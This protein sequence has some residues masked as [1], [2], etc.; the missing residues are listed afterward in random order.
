MRRQIT[1]L[2]TLAICLVASNWVTTGQELKR[3]TNSNQELQGNLGF[4]GLGANCNGVN[5]GS[6]TQ[7][8]ANLFY[9]EPDE[10]DQHLVA[11]W[12]FE[13]GP[14]PLDDSSPS[15]RNNKLDVSGNIRFEDGIAKFPFGENGAGLKTASGPQMLP[16][17]AM[18]L[19]IRFKVN[20]APSDTI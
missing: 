10:P 4:T 5:F 18:T 6:N 14:T 12:C 9:E 11:R 2:L 3:L 16:G 8:N 17:S 15:G 1:I 13:S 7:S 19:W 20:Q